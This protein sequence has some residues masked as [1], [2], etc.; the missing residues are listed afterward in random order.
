MVF[1]VKV[2]LFC[3]LSKISKNLTSQ[4][5]RLFKKDLKEKRSM[6]LKNEEIPLE[7]IYFFFLSAAFQLNIIVFD[8][9]KSKEKPKCFYYEGIKTDRETLTLPIM[10]DKMK[11]LRI[12]TQEDV[13]YQEDKNKIK[14]EENRELIMKSNLTSI[15]ENYINFQKKFNI[16]IEKL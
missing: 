12:L 6:L 8:E 2:V 1:I 3:F 11:N 9:E 4:T 10:I 7:P 14:N 15:N 5:D 16:L 13:E